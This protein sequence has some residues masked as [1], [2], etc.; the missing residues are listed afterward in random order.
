[1]ILLGDSMAGSEGNMQIADVLSGQHHALAEHFANLSRER[2]ELP[3]FAIEH[4]L[5]DLALE[6]L[7]RSVSRQ[8]EEDPQLAGAAWSWRYL[9]LVVVATEVGYRYRG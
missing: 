5:D 7:R 3:V 4:G 6:A 8:L 2:G 1:M 9:A